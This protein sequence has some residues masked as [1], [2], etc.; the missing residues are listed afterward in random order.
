MKLSD[1]VEHIRTLIYKSF[2]N[3]FARFGI[4]P[5]K[6]VEISK[7]PEASHAKRQKIDVL[8]NSHKAETG[9]YEAAR[10]KALDELTFTLFNRL[11]SIKVMEAHQLFPPIVTKEAEH[12]DRSFGHKVW[13][14]Q[15]PEMRS[16]ELEGLRNYFKYEFNQLGE[17]IPLF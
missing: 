12:G 9:S 10:E 3:E 4:G 6:E 17:S 13:L 14:E 11:A 2:N 15:N 8:I 7:I 5:T 1:H 16:E